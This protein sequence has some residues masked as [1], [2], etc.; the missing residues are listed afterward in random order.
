MIALPK[1]TH[2]SQ[3][4]VFC[5]F[6]D[7]PYLPYVFA[8]AKL[9]NPDKCIILLG[10]ESNRRMAESHGIIHYPFAAIPAG[11]ET[12]TFQKVYRRI[13]GPKNEGLRGSTD[14]IKFVFERWFHIYDFLRSQDLHAFWHFDS[15]TMLLDDLSVYEP[16]LAAYDCTEQCNGS[17]MNGYITNM[18]VLGRYLTKIN[19]VFQRTELLTKLE[20]EF[21]EVN[22]THAFTEMGAYVIFKQEEHPRTF[23]LGAVA[24]GV[25]FD[26]CICQV[27][28]MEMERLYPGKHIKKIFLADNGQFY[29]RSQADQALVHLASINLSWVPI[30]VFDNVLRHRQKRKRPTETVTSEVCASTHT[31]ATCVPSW[32]YLLLEGPREAWRY[33]RKFILQPALHRCF[34]RRTV[35]G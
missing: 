13:K 9:S 12:A 30:F 34:A 17:C 33:S 22:P 19:E 4:I 25:L 29:C 15:D 1:H 31:L 27:H 20:Q 26:D 18:D 32:S 3:P 7:S 35:S 8:C 14:W 23:H 10:D 21:R 6:G 28:G 11:V 24:N 2:H 5:H 16:R